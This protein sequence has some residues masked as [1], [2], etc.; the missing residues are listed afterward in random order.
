MRPP[1]A[2]SVRFVE[3]VVQ[4]RGSLTLEAAASIFSESWVMFAGIFWLRGR[5]HAHS[6]QGEGQVCSQA[7][8]EAQ[9]TLSLLLRFRAREQEEETQEE[10]EKK[11]T[12]LGNFVFV[13]NSNNYYCVVHFCRLIP[14]SLMGTISHTPKPSK[15]KHDDSNSTPTAAKKQKV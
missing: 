15:R 3:V 5:L 7:Q 9:D 1:V 12:P 13:E 10:V 14:R 8:Q 11:A 6:S 2:H 4:I